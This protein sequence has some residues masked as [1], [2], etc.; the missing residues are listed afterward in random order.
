LS[1][2]SSLVTSPITSRFLGMMFNS[3]EILPAQNENKAYL[4]KESR[5]GKR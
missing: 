3:P 4:T 2:L 5:G 1:L